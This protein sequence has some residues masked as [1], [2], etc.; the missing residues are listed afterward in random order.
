VFQ[1]LAAFQG[2][3]YASF[4]AYSDRCA[5]VVSMMTLGVDSHIFSV[6]PIVGGFAREIEKACTK[7]RKK[8]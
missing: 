1:V 8:I 7:L 6:P 5:E 4:T 2:G 3:R